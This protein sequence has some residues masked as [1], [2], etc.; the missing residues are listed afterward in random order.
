MAVGHNPIPPPGVVVGGTIMA[1]NPEIAAT[2]VVA[3]AGGTIRGVN[4]GT[5]ATEV[6]AGS[7]NVGHRAA[8][9]IGVV[10]GG[11]MIGDATGMPAVGIIGTVATGALIMGAAG[12][13]RLTMDEPQVGPPMPV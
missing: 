8:P 9:P 5:P 1:V 10:A 12:G 13:I 11:N 4:G 7:I 6:G 3:R 2:G